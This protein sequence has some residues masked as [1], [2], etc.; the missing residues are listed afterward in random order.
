M[1][2]GGFFMSKFCVECGT[3]LN[4]EDMFCFSCGTKFG[5]SKPVNG[6]T[7]SGDSLGGLIDKGI[8]AAKKQTDSA[9]SLFGGFKKKLNLP[10]KGRE[11]AMEDRKE[12][13][14]KISEILPGCAEKLGVSPEECYA[15]I[16][17]ITRESFQIRGTKHRSEHRNAVI[18]TIRDDMI[19]YIKF[20]RAGFKVHFFNSDD[21]FSIPFKNVTSITKN[22]H[23]QIELN[24]MGD[25]PIKIFYVDYFNKKIL[26][27][28]L[29]KY[30]AYSSGSQSTVVAEPVNKA[31]TLIKYKELLD[32]GVLTEEEFQKLKDELI[33]S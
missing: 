32:Q 11:K 27:E 4:D 24:M 18:M 21:V 8:G 31:D 5:E 29:E 2:C 26:D 14:A 9:S 10:E 17:I 7:N 30:N 15:T 13:Q 33:N 1:D 6:S 28:L 16:L 19:S 22:K 3:E 12:L 25:Q 23:M 20:G